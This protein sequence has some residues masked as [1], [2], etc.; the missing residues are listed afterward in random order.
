MTIVN[1]LNAGGGAKD[2]E[3]EGNIAYVLSDLGLNIYDVTDPLNTLELGHYYSDGYLGHSIAVYNDYVFTAADDRGL[4][5]INVTTP[6]NPTLANTYTDTRPAAIYIQ[7]DLLFIANWE[8]D[9]EIYNI[10]NTPIIAEIITFKGGGFSYVFATDELGFGF[11]N[12]G[13]LVIANTSNPESIEFLGTINDEELFSIAIDG[14]Y[15]YTGGP[16]GIKVFDSTNLSEPLLV[17]HVTKTEDTYVTNLE[18]LD[19]FLY[20][21]DFYLGFRIFEIS[22]SIHLTEIGRDDVGGSPLGFKVVGGIGYVASQVRGLEIILIQII[23][24]EI[25]SSTDIDSSVSDTSSTSGVFSTSDGLYFATELI[26][27]S[28]LFLGLCSRRSFQRF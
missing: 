9:F 21:S 25:S 10:T 12:N 19:G 2:I 20:A 6:S 22:D 5:I 17:S 24:V 28:I 7:N 8:Y 1:E 26:F 18:I 27:V 3:I 23:E 15:W 13:S 16:T 14:N 4:K 11:A